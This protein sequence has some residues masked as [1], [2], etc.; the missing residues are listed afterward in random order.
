VGGVQVGL[1]DVPY[2]V[3]LQPAYRSKPWCGGSI[4]NHNTVITAAHCI[5]EK[6]Y[7]EDRWELIPDRRLY[8]F[9]K[10]VAAENELYKHE[11][12]EQAR[13]IA[14]AVP[15]PEYNPLTFDNDIAILKLNDSFVFN[16]YVQPIE[17]LTEDPIPE[18]CERR[19][20]KLHFIQRRFIKQLMQL[21]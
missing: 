1:G 16:E 4:Y 21:C 2:Q 19:K 15:H 20:I 12:Q 11:G 14:E 8:C 9:V 13:T 6:V 3:S 17:I 7:G 18:Y 5:L 10:A